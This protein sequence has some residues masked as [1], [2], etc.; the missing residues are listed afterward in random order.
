M[1]NDLANR[2]ELEWCSQAYPKIDSANDI[3]YVHVKGFF[4]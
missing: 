4:T 1:N 2:G 3:C